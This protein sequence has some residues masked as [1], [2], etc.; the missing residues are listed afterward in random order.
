ML[1]SLLWKAYHQN[2]IHFLRLPF[3]DIVEGNCITLKEI[4]AYY[5]NV[6]THRTIAN[7][8]HIED[9]PNGIALVWI[10]CGT[11][12]RQEPIAV[13]EIINVI[14]RMLEK[15]A[16]GFDRLT[17]EFKAIVTTCPADLFEAALEMVT[18]PPTREAAVTVILKPEKD[19]QA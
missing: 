11:E 10:E 18:T 12:T 4:K 3:W 19:E 16:P 14:E 8:S 5:E 15:K 1:A 2:V 7:P 9:Y 13:Q 17:A 6:H